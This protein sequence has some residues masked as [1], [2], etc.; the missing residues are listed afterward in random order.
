[1]NNAALKASLAEDRGLLD[2]EV[3]IWNRILD[4]NLRGPMLGA[5]RVLPGMPQLGADSIIMITSGASRHSVAGFATAYTTSRAGM[6]G[7]TRAIATKA[8][9]NYNYCVFKR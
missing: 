7:V 3:T 5:R 9:I 2:A 6:N 8:L 1:V 4:V